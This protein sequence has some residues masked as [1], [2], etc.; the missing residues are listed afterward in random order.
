ME[1]TLLEIY[2]SDSPGICWLQLVRSTKELP[3]G[4]NKPTFAVYKII[5]GGM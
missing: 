2:S 1:E 4:D 3:K 5:L